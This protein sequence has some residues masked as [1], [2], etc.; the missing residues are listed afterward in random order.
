MHVIQ[1]SCSRQFFI[2]VCIIRISAVPGERQVISL[3]NML[4]ATIINSDNRLL[5]QQHTVNLVY[6]FL[7]LLVG[8]RGNVAN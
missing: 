5:E 2:F 3:I 1:F 7:D 4:R 8:C 6:F